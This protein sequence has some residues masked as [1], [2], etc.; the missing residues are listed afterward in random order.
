MYRPV[1]DKRH[2]GLCHCAAGTPAVRND[3]EL[4]LGP[5]QSDIQT[6]KLLRNRLPSELEADRRPLNR[7]IFHHSVDVPHPEPNPDFILDHHRLFFIFGIEFPG[8]V[9]KDD[10]GVL[11]SL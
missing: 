9:T 5:R 11:Q 7:V 6:P 3:N 8:C 4:L 2:G 1:L 10:D